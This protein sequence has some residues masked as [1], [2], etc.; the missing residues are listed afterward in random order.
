[1]NAPT[2]KITL[3]ALRAAVKDRSEA[4]ARVA[5]QSLLAQNGYYHLPTQQ[6][7]RSVEFGTVRVYVWARVKVGS[8]TDDVVLQAGPQI[9]S[10][11]NLASQVTTAEKAKGDYALA[12]STTQIGDSAKDKLERV[13]FRAGGEAQKALKPSARAVHVGGGEASKPCTS[14]ADTPSHPQPT[15]FPLVDAVPVIPYVPA[16]TTP[17]NEAIAVTGGNVYVEDEE[18]EQNRIAP[19]IPGRA[20]Y[21]NE[22][23]RLDRLNDL[24]WELRLLLEKQKNVTT[25]QAFDAMIAADDDLAPWLLLRQKSIRTRIAAT[26]ARAKG[27]KDGVVIWKPP[28]KRTKKGANAVNQTMKEPESPGGW[29]DQGRCHVCG[30]RYFDFTAHCGSFSDAARMIR[31]HNKEAYRG[32]GSGGYKSRGSALWALRVCKLD[33]WYQK[34]FDCG[35]Y[36]DQRKGRVSE[37]IVEI[38]DDGVHAKRNDPCLREVDYIA[39]PATY[40]IAGKVGENVDG[41]MYVDYVNGSAFDIDQV[42]YDDDGKLIPF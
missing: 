7:V 33:A 19:H 1:M 4:A 41:S 15:Q 17:L 10:E 42:Q 2:T 36:W 13:V 28:P 37:S 27:P 30:Q 24:Q 21:P 5:I 11:V 20:K 22:G 16:E 25:Q 32:G 40:V 26:I 3:P 14:C 39:P 34:H 18:D 23:Q 31:E 12:M 9:I 29:V 6:A 38:D 35:M 8:T